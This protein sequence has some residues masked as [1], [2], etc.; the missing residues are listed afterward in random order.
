[1]IPMNE[2]ID[3]NK[4]GLQQFYSKIS[5]VNNE[6]FIPVAKIPKDVLEGSLNSLRNHILKPEIH[7]KMKLRFENSFN[8]YVKEFLNSQTPIPL[9][10]IV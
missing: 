6:P 7:S 3:N 4:T 2:F 10:T 8:P 9:E 1:M 5:E